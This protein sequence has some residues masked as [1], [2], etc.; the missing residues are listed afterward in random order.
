MHTPDE[1][2]GYRRRAMTEQHSGNNFFNFMRVPPKTFS[3]LFP[4]GKSLTQRVAVR[5][6]FFKYVRKKQELMYTGLPN[7]MRNTQDESLSQVKT[8]AVL[9]CR[10]AEPFVQER[11]RKGKQH[12]S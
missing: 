7:G 4:T 11:R 8:E 3:R 5:A 12:A 6:E 9:G 1:A 10:A 2:T